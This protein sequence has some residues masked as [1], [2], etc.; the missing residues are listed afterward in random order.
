MRFESIDEIYKTND[1]IRQELKDLLAE[2]S[3]EELRRKPEA[4]KWS[5]AEVVEH[6]QMVEHSMVRISAKLLEKAKSNGEANDGNLT[7]SPFFTE[8]SDEIART[9]VEAPEFVRPG[10]DRSVEESLAAMAVTREKCRGLKELF[11]A[12]NGNIYK[13]PHPFFGELSAIEWLG[14][15][16]SHEQRHIRQIRNILSSIRE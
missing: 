12:Y 2:I 5:I 6:L 15:I 8:R 9:K 11:E 14:L 13:F 10:G 16:G 4:G 1:R 7:F 3:N